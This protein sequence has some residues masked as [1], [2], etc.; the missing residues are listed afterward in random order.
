MVTT[1]AYI[2]VVT[3]AWLP[4]VLFTVLYWVWV[5]AWTKNPY[6]RLAMLQAWY[7]VTILS[8][9]LYISAFG[10]DRIIARAIFTFSFLPLAFLGFLQLFLLRKAVN[11]SKARDVEARNDS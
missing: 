7:L 3:L 5:P 10:L 11:S 4:Q 2:F 6:G 1:T 9:V 8:T